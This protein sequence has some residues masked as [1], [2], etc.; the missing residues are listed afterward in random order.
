MDG[1]F[2]LFARSRSA[3]FGLVYAVRAR[4]VPI[5]RGLSHSD[6]LHVPVFLLPYMFGRLSLEP[7]RF[8]ASLKRD[9]NPMVIMALGR[10]D[11]RAGGFVA[12]GSAASTGFSPRV[13]GAIAGRRKVLMLFADL[14]NRELHA[15]DVGYSHPLRFSLSFPI[16]IE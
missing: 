12:E 3:I 9:N 4:L 8:N 16:A 15:V 1:V 14:S 11:Y 6:Q 2:Y 5:Y 13:P 7:C 10:V